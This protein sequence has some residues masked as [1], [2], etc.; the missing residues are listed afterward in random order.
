MNYIMSDLPGK[1]YWLQCCLTT[2]YIYFNVFPKSSQVLRK[3]H[4]IFHLQKQ[5]SNNYLEHMKK[6]YKCVIHLEPKGSL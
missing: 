6:I 5:S 3:I 4:L 2:V 1:G